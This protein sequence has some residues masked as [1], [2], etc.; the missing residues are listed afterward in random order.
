MGL[1]DFVVD[2]WS[3]ISHKAPMS[4]DPAG[5]IKSAVNGW[6]PAGWIGD[7]HH[8]RLQAYIVLAAYD[9]NVSRDFI[10]GDDTDREERR[11]YGDAGLVIDTI[12]SALLGE[13]QDIV[14]PG[15]ERYDPDMEAAPEPSAPAE[16]EDPVEPDGPTPEELAAN[17][18]A[19]QLQV[20]KDWLD[21][22]AR[23]VHF[24]LRM[25][26]CERKAVAL[27]DGVWLLGWDAERELVVPAVMDPGFYFPVL[28]DSLDGYDYPTKVH[29]AW[30]IPGEEYDDDKTR[31]RRITYELTD[32]TWEYDYLPDEPTYE[33]VEAARRLPAGATLRQEPMFPGEDDSP[34]IDVIERTYPWSSEPST[35]VCTVTDATWVLDDLNDARNID[36]FTYAQAAFAVDEDGEVRD[37]DLLIDFLPVVHEPN[38]PP[39]G[40]HYGQSSLSRV[41][42]I[43]DDLQNADTDS[44][45]ASATTGS[46]IIAVAGKATS[47]DDPLTGVRG[48][49]LDVRPGQV[50]KVGE[51]GGAW[52]I[53]TSTQLA[54]LR[55][56]VESLQKRMLRN[57]R[58]PG[59][60]VGSDDATEVSS[61][62]HLQLTFGPLSAMIRTMR[63]T[64]SVKYP[65][66]LKMV[67][68]IAQAN[69]ALPPGPTVDAEVAFG[70]FLPADM[71]GTLAMVKD[72][73]GAKL[74]SLETAVRMLLEVG[75]PIDDVAEE[76]GR[77]ESRDYEGAN[78][79]VD[80]TGDT[81]LARE[82]LGLPPKPEPEPQPAPTLPLPGLPGGPPAP[83]PPA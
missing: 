26:D 13:T 46:P 70:S 16:G 23:R 83:Q 80:A 9:E 64:R 53:D 49:P 79:L 66:L 65:L 21:E 2:R 45:R 30:E 47:G 73:Y 37:R 5:R 7:E 19:R 44:Q 57:A 62:F 35:K 1:K 29:F 39:A 71:A 40:E 56:Y 42:Q 76:I 6:A 74:I 50:W 69:E 14:V 52:V 31:V 8:R 34:L 11:E 33:E 77:I 38:T 4:D 63:L 10:E 60:L 27:G 41:L 82:R 48:K 28:T 15:S 59:T 68:R 3:A 25:S 17:E 22:W 36:A 81:D 24:T 78:E 61:G 67:Q 43:V 72:A 55:S 32:L 54:E 20:R 18:V 75:F 12:H 58:L 51:N